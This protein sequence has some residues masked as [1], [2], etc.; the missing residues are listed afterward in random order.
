MTRKI[1]ILQMMKL[2]RA[3]R[4][5]G[6]PVQAYGVLLDAPT[7]RDL[8]VAIASIFV[9]IL[10]T[11]ITGFPSAS[12]LFTAF[13]K[14]ELGISNSAYGLILT[15]PYVAV[16]IQLPYSAYVRRHGRIKQTFILFALLNKLSFVAPALMALTMKKADPA[17]STLLIGAVMLFASVCN[18]IADSALSTWFGAMIPNAVK[19]RYLST[20]QMLY[21]IAALGYSLLLGFVLRF[22]DQYPH[23]YTL[24]FLLASL[25]GV[26][27]IL[28]YLGARPPEQAFEP[29][30]P[31]PNAPAAPRVSDFLKPFRNPTYRSYLLFA[32]GW[33]FAINLTS[34]YFNVYMLQELHISLG[35]QTLLQ[36]ILPHIATILFMRRIGRLNDSFGF[37]PMLTLSCWIVAFMPLSW[38]FTTPDSY[39]FIGVTNFLSGI[40]NVAIDL[41]IMS[42]AIF[43]APHQERATF[44]AGKNISISLLGIVPAILLGGKLTDLLNPVLEQARY[45]LFSGHRVSSFHVLLVLSCLIRLSVIIIFLSRMKEENAPQIS[46]SFREL[47][48]MARYTV[49]RRLSMM[50]EMGRTIGR[51]LKRRRNHR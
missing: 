5:P 38:I 45:S 46:L 25:T 51:R 4:K 2:R 11:I 30:H 28:I 42:L 27:D 22:M 26:I 23:K 19:G 37:K 1:Q 29:W 48:S 40:F 7:R 8:D 3:A 35:I 16:L 21:T 20:R 49:N 36:Q 41:A 6:D 18:W 47:G 12:P 14:E 31:D 39:W 34:P 50:K 24:F 10:F 9:G 43:L 15:I 32:T 13:L 33:S 17:L 44:L